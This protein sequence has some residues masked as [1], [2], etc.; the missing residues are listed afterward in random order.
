VADLLDAV[1]EDARSYG[2]LGPGE[3]AAHRRHA[4]GFLALLEGEDLAA[5]VDLGSGGGVP[6]LVLAL[7]L[8]GTRWCLLDAMAKRTAFLR[9]AVDR[10]GVADRVEVR[11]TRAEEAGRDAELRQAADA[12]VARGFASPAVTAECAAPL[13][14]PGGVLV[15]SEPPGGA[16]RWP[17]G[18][19]GELGLSVDRRS[20]GPPALVGLRRVGPLPDRYPRRVG[21]PAKRPL[22]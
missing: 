22:W 14:R 1:L 4:E 17:A 6:G 12:V 20:S 18:P 10:L 7:A 13:L 9:G 15:V 8:P 5:A 16:D 21:V 11:T 19:L 2:F 3:A